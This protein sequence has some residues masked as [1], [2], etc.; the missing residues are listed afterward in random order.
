MYFKI[1]IVNSFQIYVPS[2]LMK[3]EELSSINN[4]IFLLLMRTMKQEKA[5][6]A[7]TLVLRQTC[8]QMLII[9]ASVRCLAMDYF[10]TPLLRLWYMPRIE[11]DT[12]DSVTNK[13]EHL[14]S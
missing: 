1:A 6:L 11:V 5:C 4:P 10:K 7:E 8:D 9:R 13:I 12:G 2:T 3:P 14:T